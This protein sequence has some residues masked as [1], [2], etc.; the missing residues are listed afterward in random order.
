MKYFRT[1][2]AAYKALSLRCHPDRNPGNPNAARIMAIINSSYEVLCDPDKRR[3]H[4]VW[5]LD[6]SHQYAF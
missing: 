6:A 4:D 2:R 1:I 3:A 5:I